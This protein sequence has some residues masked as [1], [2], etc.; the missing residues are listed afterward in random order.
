MA[1]DPYSLC[2]CGNGKK[3]KFCECHADAAEIEKALVAIDGEQRLQALDICNR[4]LAVK[5]Q[6]KAM[7]GLKATVQLQMQDAEGAE[8]TVTE[9]LKADPKNPYALALS[10]VVDVIH[11][12]T[13]E[14]VVHLQKGLAASDNQIH[15]ALL[16]AF[17]SVGM[18]LERDGKTMAAR[19]HY[20]FHVAVQ[21]DRPS[22]AMQS[23]VEID[24]DAEISPFQKIDLSP[25][26]APAGAPYATELEEANR[27]FHQG[28]WLGAAEKYEALDKKNPNQASILFNLAAAQTSLGKA[29][30]AEAWRKYSQVPD[31]PIDDAVDAEATAEEIAGEAWDDFVDLLRITYKIKDASKLLETLAV[32][33]R[34]P[35]ANVDVARLAREG[36]AP[37]RAV[38]MLLDKQPPTKED[39][40]TIENIAKVIGEFL[41]YGKETDRDARLEFVVPRDGEMLTRARL[42]QQVA[43]DQ[44]GMIEKEEVIGKE[45]AE[46]AAL[47]QRWYAANADPGSMKDLQ[48]T[49]IRRNFV[50]IMPTLKRKILDGRTMREVSADPAY[51]SRILAMIARTEQSYLARLYIDV[52]D[53]ARQSLGLA[54]A[55]KLDANGVNFDEVPLVRLHRYDLTALTD[56]QLASVYERVEYMGTAGLAKR[57][58]LEVVRRPSME[59]KVEMHRVYS[60]LSSLFPITSPEAISYLDKARH[61]AVAKKLSPA[62]FLLR[63]F[64]MRLARYEP[65]EAQRVLRTI[66][67]KHMNEPGVAETLYYRLASIGAIGPDGRPTVPTEAA[68]APAASGGGSGLWTPDQ[69]APTAPA[70]A[71]AAPQQQ[72][73]K[74]WIPGMD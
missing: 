35:R 71:A 10:A 51:R 55:A 15:A 34:A 70:A 26:Q 24:R 44:L 42:L 64:D 53:E 25:K 5:P 18:A 67:S 32:E 31:L 16:D 2:P 13:A 7:L 23:L 29:G 46:A 1:L 40:V 20:A 62:S 60:L 56:E 63:E 69:G 73:S 11:G 3:L 28:R 12:R 74:L 38:F 65:E 43:G 45:P 52:A 27:L 47:Q 9:F 19:S 48:E 4:V 41:V 58:A 72:A 30:A 22:R 14:A 8:K 66:Q 6:Q 39:P 49:Q 59:S 50:E 17:A 33:K 21:R 61:A 37:P 57:V 36:E 54:P 68:G